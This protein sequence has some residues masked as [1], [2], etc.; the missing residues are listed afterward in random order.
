M[1]KKK[2]TNIYCTWEKDVANI[3][4]SYQLRRIR[5]KINQPHVLSAQDRAIEAREY[6]DDIE[7]YDEPRVCLPDLSDVAP[8]FCLPA[9]SS[10]ASTN[11]RDMEQRGF[12]YR[13]VDFCRYRAIHRAFRLSHQSFYLPRA[14][15]PWFVYLMWNKQEINSPQNG[16]SKDTRSSVCHIDGDVV[17]LEKEYHRFFP[18][19]IGDVYRLKYGL[20]VAQQSSLPISLS[21][22]R[23]LFR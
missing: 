2:I 6:W 20:R 14:Y 21:N 8:T 17:L 23:K 13:V 4:T 9:K 16:L 3:A 10:S 7:S 19:N 15:I 22:R 1:T 12:V 11:L 5:S 18:Q